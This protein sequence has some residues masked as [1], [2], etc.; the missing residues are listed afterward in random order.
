MIFP[1]HLVHDVD[2]HAV[3]IVVQE[4][5]DAMMVVVTQLGKIASWIQASIPKTTQLA[6]P[7]P[8]SSSSG[9]PWLPPPPP[10]IRLTPVFGAAPSED[11]R[12]LHSLYASQIA[13]IVWFAEATGRLAALRRKVVV[14]IALKR[15]ADAG[16]SVP[17]PGERRV[18]M[19]VMTTLH[20]ALQKP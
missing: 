3:E 16:E 17:S 2:G 13:A 14:G 11:M 8:S 19:G 10:A 9:S 15:A 12:T 7:D 1:L 4:Y 18:F 5:G 20:D 6:V